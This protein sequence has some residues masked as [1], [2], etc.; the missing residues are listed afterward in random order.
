MRQIDFLRFRPASRPATG[1]L[2]CFWVAVLLEQRLRDTNIAPRGVSVESGF[3]SCRAESSLHGREGVETRKG[4]LQGVGGESLSDTRT[5][6]ETRVQSGSLAPESWA[7][8]RFPES[9]QL[10]PPEQ[11]D[12][13]RLGVD[14]VGDIPVCDRALIPARRTQCLEQARGRG[15]SAV[16]DAY[17]V[18]LLLEKR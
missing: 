8:R 5:E 9:L 12:T 2:C 18:R 6:G 11:I 7:S 3:D 17:P 13:H 14:V 15:R 4:S 1:G 10:F 16:V